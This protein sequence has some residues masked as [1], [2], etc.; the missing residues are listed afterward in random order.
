MYGMGDEMAELRDDIKRL[1]GERDDALKQS[2]L[3]TFQDEVT[4]WADATFPLRTHTSI[5]CH[6]V[7]EIIELVG[8]S[9]VNERLQMVMIEPE[10]DSDFEEESA[11][12]G[13]ILLHL[14][15]FNEVDLM[16][17]MRRKFEKCK[18][19]TWGKPD[20]HGVVR[21]V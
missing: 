16:S 20:E 6:L 19:R 2:Q 12:V 18:K 10:F 13:L 17:A 4:E 14:A 5:A 1:T 7:D 9:L 8:P 15:S 21:H 3:D 11:D